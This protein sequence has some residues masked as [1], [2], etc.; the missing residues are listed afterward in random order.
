[1]IQIEET[2]VRVGEEGGIA[3]KAYWNHLD[4]EHVLALRV[5]VKDRDSFERY[6]H[7]ERDVQTPDIDI[8]AMLVEDFELTLNQTLL[9]DVETWTA[10]DNFCE[11]TYFVPEDSLSELLAGKTVLLLGVVT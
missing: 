4:T 6:V 2:A 8:F 11:E 7:T 1:M 10:W 5:T 3:D 9:D